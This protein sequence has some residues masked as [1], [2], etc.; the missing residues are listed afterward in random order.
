LKAHRDNAFHEK[1]D[2]PRKAIALISGGLD[3]ALA[4]HLVQRQ[5]IDVLAVHFPSFFSGGDPE[6]PNSPVQVIAR[7]LRVPLVIREKGDDFLDIIR[8]PRYGHGKNIN[9]CVDCRIYT[10]VKARELMEET[11]SSF[12]VTGEVVGQRPMSQRRHTMR[13]IEKQSGCDGI[14]LRPLCA[15]LLPPTEPELAGMVDRE[16]LLDIQGRGR[17]VQFALAHEI[18]LEGFSAP[19][20]GC[21]LTDQ[22]YARRL[23]DLL[24]DRPEVSRT[25]LDALKTGRHVHLRPGLKIVIG[26]NQQ[27]NERLE[28][29]TQSGVLFEPGDFPGPTVLAQGSPTPEEERII[30][31]I[32]RRYTRESNRGSLVD[33]REPGRENRR[34]EVTDVADGDWIADHMI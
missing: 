23:R 9:P 6:A 2:R 31:S 18:G 5:G 4:I 21:L 22:I 29:L 14:V 27:E 7:Q 10:L 1:P 24:D 11:G 28:T 8:N 33:I 15:K 34:M 26:R 3:S 25:E 20:G 16:R 13:L 17:K 19:A 12:L 32:I 30:G